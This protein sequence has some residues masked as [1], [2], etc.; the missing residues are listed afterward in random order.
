MRPQNPWRRRLVRIP[1]R[2]APSM[3]YVGRSGRLRSRSRPRRI[4]KLTGLHF[5]E[6]RPAQYGP[7]LRGSE[8]NRRLNSAR[9]ALSS[10]F[11]SYPGTPVGA[12]RLALLAALRVV[13][14]IFVVKEQLLTR[15][16]DEFRTAVNT[17]E[18]LIREF[19]GRL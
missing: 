1:R 6:A 14:E 10:G 5:L 16:E 11:R 12:L 2:R 9:R 17:L 8:G 13:L 3:P 15:G 18:N 7:P 4:R 19:H